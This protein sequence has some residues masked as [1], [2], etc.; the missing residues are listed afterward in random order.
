MSRNNLCHFQALLITTSIFFSPSRCLGWRPLPGQ[1]CKSD[2][3]D[4]SSHQ[5]GPRID[6]IDGNCPKDLLTC[7]VLL[8]KKE[9]FFF[10]SHYIY[11][12]IRF[13]KFHKRISNIWHHRVPILISCF[14]A[15]KM[16]NKNF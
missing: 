12:V 8:Q 9:F 14:R 2:V 1:T 13:T 6:H 4:C 16:K 11:D 15:W 3:E 7:P 5:C 10:L